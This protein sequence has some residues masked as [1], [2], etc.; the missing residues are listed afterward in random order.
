MNSTLSKYTSHNFH[1]KGSATQ[2][3]NNGFPLQPCLS[4]HSPK[5]RERQR[6]RSFNQHPLLDASSL[7]VS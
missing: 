2:N 1:T 5:P 4:P 3:N 6:H 7:I